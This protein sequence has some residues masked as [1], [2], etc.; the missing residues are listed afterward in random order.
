MVYAAI[1]PK[2][3]SWNA[4]IDSLYLT[5]NND[6]SVTLGESALLFNDLMS[7]AGFE[8]VFSHWCASSY[9]HSQSF[10]GTNRSNFDFS[11]LAEI[12]PIFYKCCLN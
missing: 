3:P 5:L 6:I 10:K 12:A 4:E 1:V 8:P 7:K 11:P 9:F 2:W